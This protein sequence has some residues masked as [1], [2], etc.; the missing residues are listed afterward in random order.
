MKTIEF[1][2]EGMTCEHCVSAVKKAMT[3]VGAQGS[4]DLR[5]GQAS[6]TYDETTLGFE[7][8]RAAIE[9]E[10]YQVRSS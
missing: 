3:A 1:Q 8:I 9:E 5:S 2:V 6:A 7:Q 4:V 10:G